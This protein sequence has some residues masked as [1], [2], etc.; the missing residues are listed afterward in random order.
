[1][2]SQIVRWTEQFRDSLQSLVRVLDGILFG[3]AGSRYDTLSNLGS[4]GGRGNAQL[5]Q[6]LNEVLKGATA[7]VSVVERLILLEKKR[8]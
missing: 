5:L 2:E 1:M 3:E 4:I 6:A 7:T 8:V